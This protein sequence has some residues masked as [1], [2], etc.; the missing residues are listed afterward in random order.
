MATE[1]RIIEVSDEAHA[2]DDA[3]VVFADRDEALRVA[4]DASQRWSDLLDRLAK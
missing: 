4:F 3:T 1:R 2:S